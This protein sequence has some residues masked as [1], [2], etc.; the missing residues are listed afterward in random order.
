[1]WHG[2]HL[3]LYFPFSK[4]KK[5]GRRRTQLKRGNKQQTREKKEGT[6]REVGEA[7]WWKIHEESIRLKEVCRKINKVVVEIKETVSVWPNNTPDSC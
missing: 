2:Q 4:L 7:V 3:L 6:E 1:M 5:R